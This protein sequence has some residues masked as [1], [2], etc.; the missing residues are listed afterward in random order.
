MTT[1]KTIAL[2]ECPVV[3]GRGMGQRWRAAGL[4]ALCCSACMGPFEGGLCYLPYLH[5]NLVLPQTKGRGHSPALTNHSKPP[6][7]RGTST[8]FSSTD[9]SKGQKLISLKPLPSLPAQKRREKAI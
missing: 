7:P 8:A 4:G 1:G 5:H 9:F 3:S 2:N 6:Q